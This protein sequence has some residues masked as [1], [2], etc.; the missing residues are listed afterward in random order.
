MGNLWLNNELVDR[1]AMLQQTANGH[2]G[3]N[4]VAIEKDWWVTVVL[5]ALFQTEYCE[6]LLF[7]GGTS[8]YKGFNLIEGYCRIMTVGS[9]SESIGCHSPMVSCHRFTF[10]MLYPETPMFFKLKSSCSERTSWIYLRA[11]LR[12]LSRWFLLVCS[13]PKNE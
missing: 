1:L 11:V 9:L 10:S 13:I 2:P 6:S 5:K 7:K 8:P 3:I 4:Q 12:N